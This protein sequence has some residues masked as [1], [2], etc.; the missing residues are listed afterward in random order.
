MPLE[1]ARPSRRRAR[2]L[3]ARTAG[4][5]ACWLRSR[6][7]AVLCC[8][9]AEPAVRSDGRAPVGYG[10]VRVWRRLL[11]CAA[12]LVGRRLLT[13]RGG[14]LAGGHRRGKA[15]VEKWVSSDGAAFLRHGW[16]GERAR[17]P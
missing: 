6:P 5:R 11:A 14:V 8:P 7:F 13:A 9:R 3:Q 2:R 15:L 10:D 16:S 4:L 1:A 17:A 12:T